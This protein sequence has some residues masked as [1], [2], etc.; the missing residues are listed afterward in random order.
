VAPWVVGMRPVQAPDSD[1]RPWLGCLAVCSR[2][3]RELKARTRR[4]EWAGRSLGL[5]LV[6]RRAE[7]IYAFEDFKGQRGR[8]CEEL[9]STSVDRV[10]AGMQLGIMG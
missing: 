9:R 1:I 7:W 3:R 6:V 10:L 4:K 2:Q 8:V 5:R